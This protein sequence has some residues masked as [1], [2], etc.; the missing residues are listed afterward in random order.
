MRAD[1][2]EFDC[3]VFHHFESFPPLA[4]LFPKVPIVYILH[5]FIDETRKTN[6]NKFKQQVKRI[7]DKITSKKSIRK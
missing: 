4:Q 6:G 2:G 3:V 1:N 7:S 5:D